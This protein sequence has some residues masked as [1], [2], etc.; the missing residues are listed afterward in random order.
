MSRA[1]SRTSLT[2]LV[3]GLLL[4]VAIITG[5]HEIEQHISAIESWITKLGPWGVI[6]F[7]GLFALTTSLLLP[8]TVL[9]II[10]GVLFGLG[11]GLVAVLIG[12]ILAGTIQFALAHRLLQARIQRALATRPSLAAIQRAISHDEFRLQLL[13]RL[14]PLNPAT[15]TYVLG[16]A[17]VR[18]PGFLLALLALTPNLLIEVYFGHAG[19]HAAR[20]AG[21][22]A[23]TAHLHDLALFGGLAVCIVVMV[24]V[25]RMARKSLMQAVAGPRA[26]QVESDGKTA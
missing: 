5:G 9:C 23:R 11:W 7:I 22:T 24:V 10:A 6:A 16:A 1:Y 18:F 13:V 20:L 3:V 25:S 17:G 15:I 2:Y 14:T 4:I 8:D 21:S 12:S 19:T 26:G